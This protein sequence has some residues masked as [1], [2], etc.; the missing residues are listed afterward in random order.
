MKQYDFA[1]ILFAGPCNLRCPY[2]IGR[3]INP[4]LNRNNL[5]EFPLRN[6][7]GFVAL[8]RQHGVTEVV[9]TGTTT[10]PQLYRHEARLLA[11]LR[12]RLLPYSP[13]CI[14]KYDPSPT[15][16]LLGEGESPLLVAHQW[17]TGAAENGCFQP[18]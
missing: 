15:L 3:Q 12:E 18:V 13:S 17:A 14:D 4:A 1:N 6:L 2:C 16:P 8:I 10:D 7:D 9:F 5:N 11:W